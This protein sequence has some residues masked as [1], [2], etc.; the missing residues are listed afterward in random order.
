MPRSIPKSNPQI[1][2]LPSV[3]ARTGR[4]GSSIYA[5]I[6]AGRFPP[7]IQIGPQS[8]GWFEEDISAWLLARAAVSKRSK[9]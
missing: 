3:V 8:V 6:K 9:V 5:D 4:S 1:L 7:P 2:R